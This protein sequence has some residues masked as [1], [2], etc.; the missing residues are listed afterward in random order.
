[1]AN[2]VI[3]TADEL[4]ARGSLQRQAARRT[5]R[6]QPLVRLILK[7][8]LERGGPILVSDIIAAARH[9]PA[10][11]THDTLATLDDEDIIR[12]RAGAIDI[13]YPFS[14]GPTPFRVRF[15]GG[16]ERYACCAT[17]ALG[18]APMVGDRVEIDAPCHHCSASLRLAVTP[19]GPEPGAA[20]VMVWFGKRD[21]E[22][23]KAA[24]SL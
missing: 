12:V 20:A 16:R 8:F 2:L 13:A 22:A 7:A 4:L 17:D 21:D 5:A 11:A 14:A 6:Q 3:L 9:G 15:S 19:Q 1:M 10:E 18:M 23:C 24:D